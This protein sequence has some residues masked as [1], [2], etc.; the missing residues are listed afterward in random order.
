MEWKDK[1]EIILKEYDLTKKELADK[2]NVYPSYITDILKER[3]KKPSFEFVQSL[4]NNFNISGNWLITGKGDIK[5]SDNENFIFITLYNIQASAGDGRLNDDYPAE[6]YIKINKE[7]IPVKYRDKKIDCLHVSGD[8]M[9]PTYNNN[10]IVFFL[11][12]DIIDGEGVY[13]INMNG[14]LIIKRVQFD[15]DNQIMTIVSDNPLYKNYSVK[16][17]DTIKIIGVV[18]GKL[19]IK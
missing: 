4:N 15:F 5:N 7:A 13:I 8:S 16:E 14:M 9:T 3:N 2:L 17:V 12:K 19:D 6:E 11:Q 10:D 1:I 18:I